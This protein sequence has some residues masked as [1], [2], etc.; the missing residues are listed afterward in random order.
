MSEVPQYVVKG[1]HPLGKIHTGVDSPVG[2]SPFHRGMFSPKRVK[3][4][5]HIQGG[6]APPHGGVIRERSLSLK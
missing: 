4:L 1:L 5:H 2:W 3:P 6:G